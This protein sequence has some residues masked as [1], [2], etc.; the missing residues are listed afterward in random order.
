MHRVGLPVASFQFSCKRQSVSK[1]RSAS[2]SGGCCISDVLRLHCAKT[3]IP[4]RGSERPHI[5]TGRRR[6]QA[7]DWVK[8]SGQ[9]AASISLVAAGQAC[10]VSY[11]YVSVCSSFSKI[12]MMVTNH[13]QHLRSIK[14]AANVSLKS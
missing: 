7:A 3:S 1:G 14:I 4:D 9:P 13:L 8:V 12:G 6:V 2:L 11:S 10:G 5:C